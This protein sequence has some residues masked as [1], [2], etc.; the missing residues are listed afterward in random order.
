MLVLMR[1]SFPSTQ[2]PCHTCPHATDF[3]IRPDFAARHNLQSLVAARDP[4]LANGNA[5]PALLRLGRDRRDEPA[6]LLA[7]HPSTELLYGPAE[8]IDVLMEDV[9]AAYLALHQRSGV[10][11]R[12]GAADPVCRRPALL[13]GP[14]RSDSSRRRGCRCG[15]QADPAGNR[16]WLRDGMKACRHVA[17][18]KR[19]CG[20]DGTLSTS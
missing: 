4:D 6:R 11:L 9:L 17:G 16:R 10:G 13:S 15:Q 18:G 7:A 12:A 5:C 2:N 14:D 3:P 19:R 1:P 20:R 8:G